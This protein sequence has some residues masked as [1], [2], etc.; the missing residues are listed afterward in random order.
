MD[1]GIKEKTAV[2]TGGS[3]GIGLAIA[4]SLAL[5]GA[6][7]ILAS[8]SASNLEQAIGEIRSEVP[9]ANVSAQVL[10]MSNEASL[11]DFSKKVTEPVDILVTNTGG[12]AAGLPLSISLEQ[13][14]QGYQE[15]LRSVVFLCQSF[16][17]KM[18][19]R[20]WGRVLNITSTAAKEVIPRLPVSATFRAGLSAWV[21]N[22]AKEVGPY[23]VLVN[24]LLP[25][26]TDTS[27]LIELEKKSP[28]FYHT[29]TS[30]IAIGRIAKP[31]EIAN[32][33]AFLCSNANQFITGTDTLADGG[34][35]RSY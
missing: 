19:E 33:A 4:K 23:G 27:R 24:N 7:I 31:S 1:L 28:D 35:T 16:I 2:I 22:L 9:G 5:E 26:P 14:D 34:Y 25:G 3:Q 20:R 13:W 21:K 30:E 29:M 17:P 6:K 32:V 8:R 12:P 11:R 15:L 18:K 10:D